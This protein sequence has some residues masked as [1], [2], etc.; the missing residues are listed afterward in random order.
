MSTLSVG[1]VAEYA[2]VPERPDGTRRHV[3][4]DAP[5]DAAAVLAANAAL[6]ASPL[7]TTAEVRRWPKASVH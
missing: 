4:I 7:G 2:I 6:K 3:D 1:D 5:S